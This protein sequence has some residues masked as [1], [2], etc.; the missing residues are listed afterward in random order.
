VID[1]RRELMPEP[2]RVLGAEVNLV[3][4]TA[5]PEP[6]RLVCGTPVKIIFQLDRHRRCHL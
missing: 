3:L 2:A 4:R 6:Q 5:Q 1:E